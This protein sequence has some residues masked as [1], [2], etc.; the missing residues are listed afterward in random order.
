MNMFGNILQPDQEGNLK[1][2]I[3]EDSPEIVESVILCFKMFLPAASVSFSYNGLQGLE[4]LKLESFDIMILDLNL[5]E[6]DGM[7][8]LGQVRKFSEMPVIILT[9]R[10]KAEDK[11]QGL[12][13][14]ADDYIVKPFKPKDLIARV[15]DAISRKAQIPEGNNR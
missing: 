10:D 6:I 15:N 5:P 14:G 8:V 9:V 7:E 13:L 11:L 4:L 12:T 2:L 3:I 1:V